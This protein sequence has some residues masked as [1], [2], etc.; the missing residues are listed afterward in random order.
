MLVT[1]SGKPADRELFAAKASIAFAI[2]IFIVATIPTLVTPLLVD[3]WRTAFGWK[4]REL[5]MVAALELGGFAASAASALYWQKRWNW[6]ALSGIALILLALANLASASASTIAALGLARLL[7]GIAAGII[8]GVHLAFIANTRSA[9]RIVAI[10]TFFQLVVQASVFLLAEPIAGA[11]GI[12]GIYAL[13]SAPAALCLPWLGKLPSGW[14]RLPEAAL[15]TPPLLVSRRGWMLLLAFIPYGGF[16][17]GVFAFLGHIGASGA[18]LDGHAV[19]RALGASVVASALGPAAAFVLDRRA[20]IILPIVA[21]TILQAIVT[22]LLLLTHYDAWQFLA[23]IGALQAGWAF[24]S[25]YLYV[26]LID[27]APDLTAVS[28]PVTTLSGALGTYAAGELLDRYGNIGLAAGAVT[29]LASIIIVT[30]PKRHRATS[31]AAHGSN[32]PAR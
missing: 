23:Y 29:M 4:E 8:S 7:C 2:A 18:N 12:N 31:A 17:V 11:I 13:M 32:I 15:E 21:S 20:G 6:R 22:L 30:R 14:P 16:Q 1:Q 28:I 25:C 26:A 9:G 19:S 24:L 5:G 3:T 27:A 10:V